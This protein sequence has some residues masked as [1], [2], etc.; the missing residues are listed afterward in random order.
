MHRLPGLDVLR[1]I[2]ILWMMLF[3]SWIVGGLGDPYDA[4]ARYGWMG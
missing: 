1:A 3:H 4:V 2:A